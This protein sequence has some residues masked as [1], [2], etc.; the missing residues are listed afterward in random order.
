VQD[1]VAILTQD[2]DE[3]PNV[4]AGIWSRDEA[5][6]F[7]LEDWLRELVE[8]LCGFDRVIGVFDV[9]EP[10]LMARQLLGAALSEVDWAEIARHY[11]A[12]EFSE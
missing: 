3:H 5:L 8:E 9:P 2:V 10:S 11:L 1:H 7:D 6:L 12:D 4:T